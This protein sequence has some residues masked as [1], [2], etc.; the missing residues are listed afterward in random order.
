MIEDR[1]RRKELR[2]CIVTPEEAS[3]L[4]RDGMTVGFGGYTSSG[5]P[6]KIVQELARRKNAGE[7]IAIDVITGSNNGPL[8][9]VL[10]EAKLARRRTPLIESKVLAGCVNRGEVKYCEQQMHKMPR[11][12]RT[13]AFG[14][15]DVAVVEALAITEKGEI[16]P[17]SSVGMV[18]N[19]LDAAD[20][21]IV[22]INTAQ[23]LELIGMHDIY[24]P[25]ARVPIPLSNIADHIGS[26]SIPVD[27]RKIQF[28]VES[29]ELDEVP[30]FAPAKK[31]QK[32]LAKNL[33]DFLEIEMRRGGMKTLPPLQTG[34]GNLANEVVTEIGKS[35][36]ND[37][38]FFC[39]GAQKAN[40]ALAAAG[41]AKGIS[42]GS[43]QM[44]TDVISL[45]RQHTEL[46]R[47]RVVIRN[48][49]VTNSSE[50]IGRM[51]PI[52]LTSGIEMDIY[53]NVNSSHI[54]GNRVVNG[55]GGGANFAQNAGLSVMMLVSEN[56]GGAISTIVPMVSH[57][58]ISE[59]DID[60]VVTEHGVADLR[61]KSDE[62]RALSIIGNCTGSYKEQLKDYFVR[63][64]RMGGHHPVLLEEAFSWH[65][66][67]MRTGSMS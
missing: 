63:A 38:E 48:G 17:T 30:P 28:I 26:C 53:G 13:G 42:C 55:L 44:S 60:V 12:I 41:K 9:T 62:E 56:K 8:D 15:I 35:H 3:L 39:G 45:L 5:Y 27:I 19:L 54:L 34:F 18:P 6:K 40:L 21:I 25:Q 1:I 31:E 47:E 37:I 20:K 65:L 24:R 46:L 16:I 49:E 33:F 43:L 7:A 2:N 29:E 23:P 67:M 14:G 10:G 4:I 57:Q 61:G 50:V 11:L 52:T 32:A 22:E 64:R 58:D 66:K 59:H 51:S 36:F